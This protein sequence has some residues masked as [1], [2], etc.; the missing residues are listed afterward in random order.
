MKHRDASS[1]W[2]FF[3]HLLSSR[4]GKK[5]KAGREILSKARH[6]NRRRKHIE[7]VH[8]FVTRQTALLRGSCC[9]CVYA[10]TWI[11]SQVVP[12]VCNQ[13]CHK[14]STTS[15]VTKSEVK[16]LRGSLMS[17]FL[18]SQSFFR[19]CCCWKRKYIEVSSGSVSGENLP[20]KPA[21]IE[22]VT[23]LNPPSRFSPHTCDQCVA[24]TLQTKPALALIAFIAQL[25]HN[26]ATFCYGR[27]VTRRGYHEINMTWKH[28]LSRWLCANRN[29]HFQVDSLSCFRCVDRSGNS[30]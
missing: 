28:W 26:R 3:M 23:Q 22:Y 10:V 4:M 6:V 5:E 18:I 24:L 30:T 12:S 21:D 9:L 8:I 1:N 7:L 25:L 27:Q 11:S 29:N 14:G 15:S 2:L 17:P 13:S 20:L 19:C 16:F